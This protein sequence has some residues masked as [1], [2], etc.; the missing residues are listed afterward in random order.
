NLLDNALRVMNQ[1]GTITVALAHEGD[2]ATISI[3]DEGPGIAEEDL[4]RIFDRFYRAEPSR[5]RAKG[6]AG[7][8][9]A[10]VRA[11]IE[12][13]AGRIEVANRPEGGTVFT[14]Y[15]PALRG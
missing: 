9:L 1:G 5:E 13:H 12:R 15:L 10:I 2:W 3:M 7:L 4:A 11:I 6:G 14:V 8:G